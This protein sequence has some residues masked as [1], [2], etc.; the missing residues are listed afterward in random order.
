MI[1]IHKLGL[2]ILVLAFTLPNVSCSKDKEDEDYC[3]RDGYKAE[4]NVKLSVHSFMNDKYNVEFA[5]TQTRNAN[6]YKLRYTLTVFRADDKLFKNPVQ[7]I[8][9]FSNDV[10]LS[11]PIGGYKLFA[12][13]D[14][15]D[16]EED[17]SIY[18]HTDDIS[19]ILLKDRFGYKGNDNW[20]IGYMGSTDL[21][22]SYRTPVPT[23]T[24]LPA[25]AEYRIIAKDKP[26]YTVKKV[27]ISYPDGLPASMNMST[28]NIAYIWNDVAFEALQSKYLA[29]DQ[30]FAH[31][32]GEIKVRIAVYDNND[33]IKARRTLTIP[34]ERGCIT[35]AT[36]NIYS[37]LEN[38]MPGSSSGNAGGS[39][40]NP[41]YDDVEYIV[42]G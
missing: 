40:I 36:G 23:I 21:K 8:N 4:L 1:H 32:K 35:N 2:S 19:D 14:Y 30:L 20:K 10:N 3:L 39:M 38:E 28:G 42:I 31:D 29:F 33:E 12:W 41:E 13:A 18:F 37:I 22:V 17:K 16:R 15:S 11:L 9:T 6:D 24:L 27:V 25:M 7:T 26:D 34:I 5:D